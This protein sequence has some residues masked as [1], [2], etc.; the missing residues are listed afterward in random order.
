MRARV[1]RAGVWLALGGGVALAGTGALAE[2]KESFGAYDVHYSVINATYLRPEIA[3]RYGVTRGRDRALANVSVLD[4]DGRA[5]A[6][7][8]TG[9]V[10]NL[11]GQS[12]PLQFRRFE[13]GGAVYHLATFAFDDGEALR[14]ELFADLPDAGEQAAPAASGGAPQRAQIRF[15]QTLHWDD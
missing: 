3:R 6:V 11:L 9:R 4:A 2:R 14:F 13:D 7:P 15:Q 8:V 5:I 1:L 10:K 12:R